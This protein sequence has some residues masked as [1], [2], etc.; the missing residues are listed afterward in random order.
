MR[1]S[2]VYS[3]K[4]TTPPVYM[5]VSLN[6]V[7][8]RLGLPDSDESEDANI[9]G[10]I[11]AATQGI[12]RY[13]RRT[14]VDTVWTM[15]LDRFPGK[16]LP[17]WDGVREMADTQL[18]DLIEPIELPLPPID[19]VVHV[20]A[21]FN[22]GTSTTVDAATYFVD[23]VREPG[24][25]V[26]LSGQSWPSGLMRPANAVEVQYVA[27]YGPVGSDVPEPIRDAI[28]IYVTDMRANKTGEAFKFEK[29][30]DSSVSRFG[31]EETGTLIPRRAKD[32][33]STYRVW[34]V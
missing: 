26:L 15:F 9:V 1:P 12:E 16:E 19:S 21:H 34:K 25:I 22:D 29:V 6:E 27:G 28:M 31:P 7:K 23:S 18:T 24:R 20:K 33:L 3:I 8:A 2:L 10:Q 32:L 30:G 13:L 14:L 11:R 4:L 5:P 17:W